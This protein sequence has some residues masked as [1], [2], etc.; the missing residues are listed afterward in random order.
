MSHVSMLLP[1]IVLVFADPTYLS[2]SEDVQLYLLAMIVAPPTNGGAPH[3]G[4]AQDPL[5]FLG[6]L[7]DE[8]TALGNPASSIE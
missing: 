3:S 7:G 6:L 8:T 1:G 2:A 4:D 5:G